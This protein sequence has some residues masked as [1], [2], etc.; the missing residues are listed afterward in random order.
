M[1]YYVFEPEVAVGLARTPLWTPRPAH[2]ALPGFTT[3]SMAGWVMR[4][5]KQWR[6][7]S[8][9]NGLPASFGRCARTGVEYGSVEVDDFRKLC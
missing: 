7:S 5:W 9:Q 8:R 2:R 6:A 3:D 1:N 4:F